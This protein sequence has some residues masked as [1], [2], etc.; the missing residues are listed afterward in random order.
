MRLESSYISNQ[1]TLIALVKGDCREL[2]NGFGRNESE[3]QMKG[4]SFGVSQDVVRRKS[5]RR[6]KCQ[7]CSDN[8]SIKKE[9]CTSHCS[10][11]C[12]PIDRH[13]LLSFT[14]ACAEPLVTDNSERRN[15][16][17]A[18]WRRHDALAVTRRADD[19]GGVRKRGGAPAGQSEFTEQASAASE[20]QGRFR[21]Y[22][23]YQPHQLRF[24]ATMMKLAGEGYFGQTVTSHKHQFFFLSGKLSCDL[25]STIGLMEA[26]KQKMAL[27]YR[28]MVTIGRCGAVSSASLEASLDRRLP[29]LVHSLHCSTR[30]SPG[31]PTPHP[32]SNTAHPLRQT[33]VRKTASH[34]TTAFAGTGFAASIST[35]LR[36]ERSKLG[37]VGWADGSWW[38]VL[39]AAEDEGSS[40]D[41]A[42]LFVGG[43]GDGSVDGVPRMANNRSKSPRLLLHRRPS[44]VFSEQASYPSKP[45]VFLLCLRGSGSTL[46]WLLSLKVTWRTTFRRRSWN[47]LKSINGGGYMGICSS[48]NLKSNRAPASH[49]VTAECIPRLPCLAIVKPPAST[50]SPGASIPR[51]S[52]SPSSSLRSGARKA[53]PL[54]GTRTPSRPQTFQRWHPNL[55]PKDIP[56]HRRWIFEP[57]ALE[58]E[59]DET[60][61]LVAV[62]DRYC[63]GGNCCLPLAAEV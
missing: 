54:A 46:E 31:S 7:K 47:S 21:K 39:N 4:L 27:Q 35:G 43:C 19:E 23:R 51:P 30:M 12:L 56:F 9:H 1:L 42:G 3:R 8:A 17:V 32:T 36:A 62:C 57:V 26:D 33:S 15:R 25:V 29:G 22:L 53:M 49:P 24:H 16:L 14:A 13:Q 20:F 63:C 6:R 2:S 38:A 58:G 44:L 52:S 50:S 48:V 11:C 45:L 40:S 5:N 55:A 28:N 10:H 18:S 37:A 34:A 41:E 61:P 59:A 60:G